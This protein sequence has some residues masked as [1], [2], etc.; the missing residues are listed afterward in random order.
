MSKP[1]KSLRS[2]ARCGGMDTKGEM[3][4]GFVLN[5]TESR[6]TRRCLSVPLP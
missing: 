4:T 1:Q 5:V 2:P 6:N 3:S